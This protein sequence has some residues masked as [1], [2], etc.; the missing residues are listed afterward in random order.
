MELD[1]AV[2][3]L[4]GYVV[5]GKSTNVIALRD[6]QLVAL[7]HLTGLRARVAELEAA[8]RH[9][10]DLMMAWGYSQTAAEFRTYLNEG[11]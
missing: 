1:E 9:G 6:A 3:V 7:E 2:D 8:V 4:T 10:A 11:A 5:D